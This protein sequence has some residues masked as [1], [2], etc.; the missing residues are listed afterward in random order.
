MTDNL[1]RAVHANNDVW[2][3][4]FGSLIST[5]LA[6]FPPHPHLSGVLLVAH[7]VPLAVNWAIAQA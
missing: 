3:L 1:Y 2:F 7:L 6:L 5:H 4:R